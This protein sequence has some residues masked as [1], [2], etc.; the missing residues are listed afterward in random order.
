MLVFA[1]F[2]GLGASN[3]CAFAPTNFFRPD[4]QL[5]RI[6]YNE[7]S[8]FRMGAF[9]EYGDKKS[10]KVKESCSPVCE[11]DDGKCAKNF[12]KSTSFVQVH[13]CTESVI[14][15]L[16]NP[17]C[18]AGQETLDMLNMLMTAKGGP[19][20]DDGTRG[21]VEFFGKFE[22]FN[23]NI[24]AH[25]NFLGFCMPGLMSLGVYIPIKSI[26]LK[27]ICFEDKTQE[28]FPTDFLVKD[29]IKDLSSNTLELGCL[30]IGN[31]SES[32]IGDVIIMLDWAY[33]YQTDASIL[34]QVMFYV[35]LGL[36]IP[37]AQAKDQD[38][39]FSFALGNDGAWG[40][41]I[42]IGIEFDFKKH[43]KTGINLDLLVLLN[44]ERDRRAKTEERQTE[45]LLLNKTNVK[46][47][48]GLTWNIEFW[49]QLVSPCYGFNAKAMYQ[50]VRHETDTLFTCDAGYKHEIINSAKSLKGWDMHNLIFTLF[51][52][53]SA[54]WESK[55]L[56]AESGLFYKVGLTG[57]SIIEH[58]TIGGYFGFSF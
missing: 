23:A 32:G 37:S 28:F 10:E 27:N 14:A 9:F 57:D 39:A 56:H 50:Y 5:F 36:S 17:V 29:F 40:F 31:F 49:L 24:W 19:S 46:K 41:P 34:E 25:I 4:D 42:G 38:K 26:E 20:T 1:L 2:S 35:K 51:Y 13:D 8:W 33:W 55:Q 58:D 30:D 6:P 45:F 21:H 54:H 48:F 44:D 43:F 3:I 12:C 7:N 18:P 47:E 53:F 11:P 16:R 15:M 52:D 22:E